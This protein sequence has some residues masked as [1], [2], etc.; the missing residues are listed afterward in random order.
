MVLRWEGAGLVRFSYLG[1]KKDRGGGG[2]RR[3][4]KNKRGKCT[5]LAVGLLRI[6]FSGPAAFVALMMSSFFV[7]HNS[8]FKTAAKTHL[9]IFA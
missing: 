4:T 5:F 6:A 8:G 9:R 2:L 7:K 3:R 1:Q